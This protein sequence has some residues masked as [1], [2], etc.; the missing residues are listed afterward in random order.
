[1]DSLEELP[2][3]EILSSLSEYQLSRPCTEVASDGQ[4]R[5]VQEFFEL[6]V[7]KYL[8]GDKKGQFRAM[9]YTCF[10]YGAAEFRG[11]GGTEEQALMDSLGRIRGVPFEQIFPLTEE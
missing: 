5:M 1:M 2:A 7:L 4:S 8:N 11:E 9:P 10:K 6:R 3:G